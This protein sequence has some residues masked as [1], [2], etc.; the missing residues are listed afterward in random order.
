MTALILLLMLP[1][2][3]QPPARAASPKGAAAA[4]KKRRQ[5]DLELATDLHVANTGATVSV[6]TP[7]PIPKGGPAP[8]GLLEN[9]LMP[10]SASS[11]VAPS[12]GEGAAAPPNFEDRLR[13]FFAYHEPSQL[14]EVER[15]AANWRGREG[16][17][18]RELIWFHGAEPPLTVPTEAAEDYAQRAHSKESQAIAA[19]RGLLLNFLTFYAPERLMQVDS[20]MAAWAGEEGVLGERLRRQSR[21]RDSL[22]S[23]FSSMGSASALEGVIAAQEWLGVEGEL[24]KRLPR[25]QQTPVPFVV[26]PDKPALRT[27]RALSARA[28]VR[29]FFKVYKPE[30]LG[31][32]DAIMEAFEG[33]EDWLLMAL[34]RQYL[35]E[36]DPALFMDR[37][38]LRPEMKAAFRTLAAHWNPAAA[39]ELEDL[40][41]QFSG[42][43]EEFVLH[44]CSLGRGAEG[45][46]PSM[47]PHAAPDSASAPLAERALV[48]SAATAE[49]EALPPSE[50]VAPQI[51]APVA[52]KARPPPA[53]ALKAMQARGAAVPPK[54]AP[55]SVHSKGTVVGGV[56]VGLSSTGTL[57]EPQT[58]NSTP[59]AE[60]G[61]SSGTEK[62]PYLSPSASSRQSIRGGAMA[63]NTSDVGDGEPMFDAGAARRAPSLPLAASQLHGSR[64]PT[65]S[66]EAKRAAELQSQYTAYLRRANAEAEAEA[67]AAA[68][69]EANARAEAA[70]RAEEGRRAAYAQYIADEDAQRRR[71]EAYSLYQQQWLRTEAEAAEAQRRSDAERHRAALGRAP[72]PADLFSGVGR[73]RTAAASSV[74]DGLV[75]TPRQQQRQRRTVDLSTALAAIGASPLRELCEREEIAAA[76]FAT[77]AA[78]DLAALGVTEPHLLSSP[79]RMKEFLES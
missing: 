39:E 18:M 60:G 62:Q 72:P 71:R 9:I 16:E 31:E 70:A 26:H 59:L 69:A 30:H 75:S 64:D 14:P 51:T 17:L 61:D 42:S 11:L 41:W 24:L 58:P 66:G 4:K 1:A 15:W 8:R 36:A 6:L 25:T 5:F 19:T 49:L 38:F 78:S 34:R 46:P 32:L 40:L 52:G 57:A 12:G 68:E 37:S 54:A 28:Q 29:Q 7:V 43:E 35:G 77:L 67:A 23:Y 2:R 10:P 76:V 74:S 3:P 22:L 55:S 53:M 20:I 45:A 63:L 48:S 73:V 47:L 65:D 33:R 27:R 21:V 50:P 44:L 79:L 13:R 56:S